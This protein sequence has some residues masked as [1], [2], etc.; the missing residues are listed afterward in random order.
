MEKW[1]L[2][3]KDGHKIGSQVLRSERHVIPEGAFHPCVEVW[4]KVGEELLLTRRHPNKS[5]GLKFDCPGGAVLCGE[6]ILD[7]ACRELAE[8]TG[9]LCDK[10]DLVLLGNTTSHPVFASSYLLRLDGLPHLTNRGCG[11]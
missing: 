7:G 8:E 11:I 5:H 4:V 10:K 1:D 2:V 3:D 6:E 9:I